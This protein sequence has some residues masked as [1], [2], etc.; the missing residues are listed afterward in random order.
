MPALRSASEH[1][2]ICQR[3]RSQVLSYA[4][5]RVKLTDDDAVLIVEMLL[6]RVLNDAGR[7]CT[8]NAH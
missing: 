7:V 3:S 2:R 8:G 4:N 6:Q 1:E 5:G